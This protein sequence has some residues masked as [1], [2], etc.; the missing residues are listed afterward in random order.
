MNIAVVG[1]GYVAD[2][3]LRTLPEHAEIRLAGVLD[4]D[5][6]RA[7]R[8]AARAGVRCYRSLEEVLDDGS[9]EIVVNLANPSSHHAISKAA[10]LADKHVY[11][12]KP[13]AT[14]FPEAA[15][16]VTLAEERG[17]VL[18]G[19]PC[20]LLGETAQTMWK[21]LRDGAVGKARLAY[22]ELDDGPVH[23]MDYRS[24]RS[25]SGV[26]WPYVDEFEVGCTMEHAGYYLTWLCAFF[27]PARRVTSFASTIV[28]DKGVALCRESPD[29][30]V[31][32][33][34]FA[35]GVVAR[36]TCSIFA[37][38]DHGLRI[39]GDAG[40]LSTEECWDYGS[41][42][43]QSKRDRLGIRAEKHPRLARLVGLGP[44]RVPLA[45]RPSRRIRAQGGN[46][47]DFARGIAEV[48]ASIRERRSCR[49]G[50]RFALHV[51]EIVLAMASPAEMGSPRALV[52]T[53]D[54][55]EPMPWAR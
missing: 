1:C 51:N 37:P 24:W 27:G 34:D 5:P 6:V 23:L 29:F 55:V 53:F 45:R 40:V 4:R 19:A 21:A 22:A 35:N 3:Y 52:T 41:P 42:V 15:E 7:E 47:M 38:H 20:S 33:V 50:A 12:E 9:V 30:S 13:L 48:A 2:L 11:S 54:A 28:P 49:L 25:D 44:R 8:L 36:L 39:V 10:L 26:P 46:P 32:C 14:S 43:Y 17:L 31:A 16:L 18:A